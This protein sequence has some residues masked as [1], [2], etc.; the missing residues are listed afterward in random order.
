[1]GL[2]QPNK[3]IWSVHMPRNCTHHRVDLVIVVQQPPTNPLA[4]VQVGDNL[5]GLIGLATNKKATGSG[6]NGSYTGVFLDSIMGQWLQAHPQF[7][8]FTFGMMVGKPPTV[9]LDSSSKGDAGVLHWLQPD[10]AFYDASKIEWKDADVPSTPLPFASTNDW[11]V[12]IDGWILA[13]GGNHVT[14]AQSI[15]ATVDPVYQA[16]FMPMQDANLIRTSTDVLYSH[17]AR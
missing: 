2:P 10:P 13:A 16:M 4:G 9:S 8:N 17:I 7:D 1:M 11:F 5:S 14:N 6:S 12:G 15:T 3:Y